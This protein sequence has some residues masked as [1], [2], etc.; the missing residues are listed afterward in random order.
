MAFFV[1]LFFPRD[2]YRIEILS[3]SSSNHSCILLIWQLVEMAVR[4]LVHYGEKSH[5]IQ[6]LVQYWNAPLR[7]S[8]IWGLELGFSIIQVVAEDNLGK[9]RNSFLSKLL[10]NVLSFL[11][12]YSE[13]F[14]SWLNTEIETLGSRTI[15]KGWV[16]L[17]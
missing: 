16:F 1:C 10:M 14:H 3:V 9:R 6:I 4:I 5:K 13:I 12:Y 8:Y 17:E 15:C 7:N 2:P 11:N